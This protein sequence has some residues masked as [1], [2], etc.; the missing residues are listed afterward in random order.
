DADAIGA[1]PRSVDHLDHLRGTDASLGVDAIWLSPI[2]PSPLA[3]FGYD[4]SDYV[5]VDPVFGTFADFDALVEEARR[6][7][8]R[9]LLDLV[10]CHTSIEHP[11]FRE[12]P[13]WYIWSPQDGP[14]NNWTSA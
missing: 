2:Y 9:V 12:H 8:I 3:D 14:P 4:V 5:G 13:G 1:L 7:V 10:A 6:R 11:W